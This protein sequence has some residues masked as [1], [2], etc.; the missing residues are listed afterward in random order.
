MSVM[1]RFAALA[2]IAGIVGLSGCGNQPDANIFAKSLFKGVKSK[3]SQAGPVSPEQTLA[4]V[5][6]TLASTDKPVLLA[7]LEKRKV[8][9]ALVNIEVNGPYRTWGSGD[10]RTITT[11]AGVVTATRGLGSDVM[12]SEVGGILPLI[13]GRKPGRGVHVIRFLDGE[14][15]TVTVTAECE[16]TRGGLH[17][18]SAGTLGNVTTTEMTETCTASE[19]SFANRYLVDGRGRVIQSRQ[20]LGEAI[21]SVAF[22]TL[23]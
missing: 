5:Q 19:R 9:A 7:F 21:G 4:G 10:R 23:R 8:T 18:L 6:S 13:T 12:S 15:H 16:I 2:A 11:R 22:Q 1:R 3:A 17:K 20:W 14:N